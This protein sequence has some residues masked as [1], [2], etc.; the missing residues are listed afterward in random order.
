LKEITM[1]KARLLSA[2]CTVAMLAASPVFAQSNTPTGDTGAGGVTNAPTMHETT[3]PS[4][5]PP[6]MS[7]GNGSPA[8]GT[9][10]P[11]H[12]MAMEQH[13]GAGAMRVGKSDTA[14]NAAVDRL[15]DQSYQAAQQGQKFN[16][17]GSAGSNASMPAG[18]S[19]SSKM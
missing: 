11:A 7:A 1:A 18:T 2:A 6:S 14:Q 13:H 16:T 15:N 19:G 17:V 3:P 8:T 9:Q 5:T 12:R 4:T 10:H